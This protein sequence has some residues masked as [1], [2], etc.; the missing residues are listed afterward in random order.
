MRRQRHQRKTACP[1]CW[2][3]F[4]SSFIVFPWL[5][6]PLHRNQMLFYHRPDPMLVSE[7][8]PIVGFVANYLCLVL[9]Y[10]CKFLHYKTLTGWPWENLLKKNYSHIQV[11]MIL[12]DG[13]PSSG[14]LIMPSL[15]LAINLSFLLLLKLNQSNKQSFSKGGKNLP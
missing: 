14:Q 11:T 12:L 4:V 1:R 8:N 7:I 13:I 3:C 6:R 9:G 15:T 2:I 5:L 10:L